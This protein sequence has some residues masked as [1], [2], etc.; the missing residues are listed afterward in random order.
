[1]LRYLRQI[2]QPARTGPK[3]LGLEFGHGAVGLVFLSRE[4]RHAAGGLEELSAAFGHGG[5]GEK[6]LGRIKGVLA[7][8]DANLVGM[9]LPTGVCEHI[10]PT[11]CPLKQG[12]VPVARS[13]VRLMSH[14]LSNQSA[15]YSGCDELGTPTPE[16]SM[17]E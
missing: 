7:C 15:E 4:F 1:V 6:F 5:S 13:V 12:A 2:H 17:V 11:I 14:A 8:V 3:Y 16:L 9:C 10:W